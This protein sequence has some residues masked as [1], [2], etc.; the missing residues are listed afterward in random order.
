MRA[1]LAGVVEKLN[2][3]NKETMAYV[4]DE[5]CFGDVN[6]SCSTGCTPLDVILSSQSNKFGG[7]PYGRATSVFGDPSDGKSTLVENFLIQNQ[8]KGY[9]GAV[10]LTELTIDK[11]RLKRRGL[12]L[13]KVIILEDNIIEKGFENFV[14]NVAIPLSQDKNYAGKPIMWIWDTVSAADHGKETKSNMERA[15]TLHNM[16]KEYGFALSKCKV[17]IVFVEQ[18][19]TT[20]AGS[21]SMRDTSGG[22]AIKFRASLRLD[23]KRLGAPIDDKFGACAITSRVKLAK[24]KICR[25]FSECLIT[26]S[27]DNGIDDYHSIFNF[28]KT[29]NVIYTTGSWTKMKDDAGKEISWQGDAGFYKLLDS[30]ET[31]RLLLRR[32]WDLRNWSYLIGNEADIK[33]N[34]NSIIKDLVS[35]SMLCEDLRSSII[36]LMKGLDY[37]LAFSM[38]ES[39]LSGLHKKASYLY[40]DYNESA[41]N[42]FKK[43]VSEKFPMIIEHFI[44]KDREAEYQIELKAMIDKK[45][46]EPYYKRQFLE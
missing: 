27:F 18:T 38:I 42:H 22:E 45:A 35:T 33:E 5:V 15:K 41:M 30:E 31:R 7:I 21:Y 39:I 26:I 1:T 20:M 28:L 9:V 3:T 40:V 37:R 25:P 10:T 16:F 19:I 17:C 34:V 8:L 12:D 4:G 24:S 13:S 36:E 29:H 43:V 32:C 46:K 23:I 14:K 6:E 2:A 44:S 11:E